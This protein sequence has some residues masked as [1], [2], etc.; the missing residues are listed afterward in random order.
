MVCYLISNEDESKSL[1]LSLSLNAHAVPPIFY[2]SCF[3]Y[4]FRS[5]SQHQPPP[6]H[7]LYLSP[8]HTYTQNEQINPGYEY[9]TY[10]HGGLHLV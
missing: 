5:S 4:R 7:A 10:L 6:L 3:M 1:S 2:D 8:S 9:Y